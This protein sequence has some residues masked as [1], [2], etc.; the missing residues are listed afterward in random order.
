[1]PLLYESPPPRRGTY[2]KLSGLRVKSKWPPDEAAF[3]PEPTPVTMRHR[4]LGQRARESSLHTLHP[5]LTW[6]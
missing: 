4:R 6:A 1:M 3:Q 2:L 5:A